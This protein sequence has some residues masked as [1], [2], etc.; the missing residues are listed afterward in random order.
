MLGTGWRAVVIISNS[1]DSNN[2][3]PQLLAESALPDQCSHSV[4]SSYTERLCSATAEPGQ[5]HTPVLPPSP[6]PAPGTSMLSVAFHS[7]TSMWPS[8]AVAPRRPFSTPPLG[9]RL[10]HKLALG[11]RP[12]GRK[13]LSLFVTDPGPERNPTLA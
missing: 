8:S 2:W 11:R 9:D 7:G 13:W 6:P 3:E 12:P 4:I 1:S 5:P 10:S